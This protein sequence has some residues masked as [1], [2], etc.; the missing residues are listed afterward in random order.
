ML[1]G[2][3]NAAWRGDGES[4]RILKKLRVPFTGQIEKVRSRKIVDQGH[5]GAP[6]RT[7]DPLKS[8]F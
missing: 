4:C 1:V 2:R 5:T 3:N 8:R 7:L 6:Y